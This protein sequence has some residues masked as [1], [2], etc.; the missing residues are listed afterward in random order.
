MA[1]DE[2]NLL[3]AGKADVGELALAELV[4]SGARESFEAEQKDNRE[5]HAF[6]GLNCAEANGGCGSVEVQLAVARLTDPEQAIVAEALAEAVSK[7]VDETVEA[8][9]GVEDRDVRP[10]EAATPHKAIYV[11]EQKGGLVGG[12]EVGDEGGLVAM[13][14]ALDGSEYGLD[15]IFV[16]AVEAVGRRE[17]A[18]EGEDFDSVAVA[19]SQDDRAL[20]LDVDADAFIGQLTTE[21]VLRGIEAEEQAVGCGIEKSGEGMDPFGREVLSFVDEDGVVGVVQRFERRVS[22]RRMPMRAGQSSV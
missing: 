2:E 22:D 17:G 1:K 6:S 9:G 7:A 20:A 11:I 5:L 3:G 10:A 14:I 4:A 21:D 12:R 16:A 15:L 19:L 8:A 13:A 18:G